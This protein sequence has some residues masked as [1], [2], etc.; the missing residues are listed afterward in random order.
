MSRASLSRLAAGS[1][2]GVVLTGAALVTAPAA[3]AAD[4]PAITPSAVTITPGQSFSLSGTGCVMKD[5]GY[6]DV[7]VAAP[8]TFEGAV[9]AKADGS[10]TMDV[11][12]Y[13]MLQPGTVQLEIT[14]G[15][16]GEQYAYPPVTVNVAAAS[17]PSKASVTVKA[18]V[19]HVTAAPGQSLTPEKPFVPGQKL[20]LTFPG[21]TAGEKTTWVLHSTPRKLGT[22]FADGSGSLATA[23]TIPSGVE[24]GDHELRVTRADGSVVTYPI[25][26][27]A[28]KKLADTGADVGW[29]LTLGVALVVAGAGALV[30]SRRRSAGA[31]QV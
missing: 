12:T 26:I 6:A 20:Q 24:A 3:L 27:A 9:V 28:G 7:Y 5:G 11:G 13:A 30:V 8:S 23:L 25:R 18:G 19:T 14:C 16:Y 15:F 1:L 29:S 10:W 22:Y 17:V 4:L 2:L 31:P 21:Y